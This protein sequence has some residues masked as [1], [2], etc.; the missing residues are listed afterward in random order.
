MFFSALRDS[1][2]LYPQLNNRLTMVNG[3][4]G[5]YDINAMLNLNSQYWTILNQK[6]A[7]AN[8]N[9]NQVQVIWFMQAQHITGIPSGQGIEHIAI[10]EEKF[11]EAFQYFKTRFPNLKQIYCSGR[12]YGGYSNPNSG[13]PEPYAYYTGWSFRNL[14]VRQMEGDDELQFIGDN[15]KTPWIAWANYAWADGINT[16]EDGFNWLCP[17]DV[18]NDGVHPNSSGK[19]KV[20]SLLSACRR[21]LGGCLV[22]P[23]EQAT[24][25]CKPASIPKLFCSVGWISISGEEG[26]DLSSREKVMY[27]PSAFRLTEAVLI[28]KPSGR[29]RCWMN[30]ISPNLGKTTRLPRIGSATS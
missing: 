15:P 30:L 12:D 13:N 27:Q 8:I 1:S 20:A 11:L 22:D 21:N 6:L 4:T 2:V 7:Q 29:G 5:G 26:T 14:V 28:T 9:E 3:A 10:M 18:E 16:R 25:Y 23:S 24:K 19:G 17:G